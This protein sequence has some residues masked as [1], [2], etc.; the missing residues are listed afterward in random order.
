MHDKFYRAPVYLKVAEGKLALDASRSTLFLRNE[1]FSN[2]AAKFPE[3]AISR[4]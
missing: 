3:I 1:N 4:L 2:Q